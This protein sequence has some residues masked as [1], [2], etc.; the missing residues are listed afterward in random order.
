MAEAEGMT[1]DPLLWCWFTFSIAA[2]HGGLL[3][4]EELV[5]FASETRAIAVA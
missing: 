4:I 1:T 3:P 2:I 5:R